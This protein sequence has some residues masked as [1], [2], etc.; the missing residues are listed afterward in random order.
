MLTA[1]PCFVMSSLSF[2]AV[3]PWNRNQHARAIMQ[4][5]MPQYD[6][7]ANCNPAAVQSINKLLIY[8]GFIYEFA[9]HA[10]CI[11]SFRADP[12]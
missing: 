8:N 7:I 11:I 4:I 12:F 9:W 3:V 10:D 6:I 1:S 5:A 2:W